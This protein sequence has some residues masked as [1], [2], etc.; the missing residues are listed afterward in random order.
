MQD[1][2]LQKDGSSKKSGRPVEP[3]ARK[4]LLN[5]VLQVILKG[6]FS[7]KNIQYFYNKEKIEDVLVVLACMAAMPDLPC[8]LD[9]HW[10]H[11]EWH[12]LP[13]VD[14]VCFR[15]PRGSRFISHVSYCYHLP[16][17]KPRN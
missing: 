2:F 8:V 7:S 9:K 16:L 1:V 6:V 3:S 17:F 10:H 4:M 15:V 13:G 12:H 14:T 5:S 11:S